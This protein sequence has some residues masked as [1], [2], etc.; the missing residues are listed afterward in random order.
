MRYKYLPL[1]DMQVKLLNNADKM[2]ISI[3]KWLQVSAADAG[4]RVM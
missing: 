1:F 3:G 2:H 4:G